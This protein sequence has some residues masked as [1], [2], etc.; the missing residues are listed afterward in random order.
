MDCKNIKTKLIFLAERSLPPDE[1]KQLLLHL[2]N[3]SSCR[4]QY[5][6][7][8]GFEQVIVKEK[9]SE[10]GP[11]FYSKLKA[12]FES[13]E[14]I[15]MPAMRPAWIRIAQ[16]GFLVII[17]F[18]AIISGLLLGSDDFKYQN[19]GQSYKQSVHNIQK[20]LNNPDEQM[21]DNFPTY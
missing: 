9:Y 6:Y 1:E 20:N 21:A 19:N 5:E 18:A 4:E 10:P 14:P 12:R 3:C 16:S 7:L 17:V 11:Y 13:L 8:K 2:E 15:D